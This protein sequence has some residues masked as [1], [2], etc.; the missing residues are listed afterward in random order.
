MWISLFSRAPQVGKNLPA[1]ARDIKDVGS[2]LGWDLLEEGT[3]THSSIL[4]WRIP[5][6]EEPG[7][8]QSIGSQRVGR[9]WSDLACMHIQF[10]QH[11][12]LEKAILSPMV[13]SCHF[14]GRSFD[15]MHNGVFL[16]SLFYSISLIC[17]F[18]CQYHA[19]WL[20]WLCVT[21]P[22]FFKHPFPF[23]AWCILQQISHN[24]IF[25]FTWFSMA[26]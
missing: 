21:C 23:T 17:L 8:P 7:G 26:P 13:W 1:N 22:I 3:G 12:L 16:S 19:V 9:D 18:L 2:S 4:A 6:T 15:H 24:I 11:H 25:T 10:S 5:W 14:C 20:L